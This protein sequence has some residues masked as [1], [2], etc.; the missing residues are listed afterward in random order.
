MLE[1]VS[2]LESLGIGGAKSLVKI[3]KG[4]AVLRVLNPANKDIDLPANRVVAPV[5][6]IDIEPIHAL[7]G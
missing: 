4:K 2:Y 5:S 7:D 6:E 3:H 1:P